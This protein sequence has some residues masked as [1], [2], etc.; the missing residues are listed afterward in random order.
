MKSF[1]TGLGI[2][3]GLGIVFAPNSGEVT[4]RQIR[5]RFTGL[6]DELGGQVDKAK[7]VVQ[8]TVAAYTESSPG[9]PGERKQTG[10]PQKK[11]QEREVQTAASGDPVN[12][13]SREELMNVDGIGPVLADKIISGRPYSSRQELVQ[14][15]IVPQNTFEELE[16][17]LSRQGRRSA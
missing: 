2:G 1:L 8:K 17:E 4:R 6:A 13:I 10:S 16:R 14:R 15:G 5:E 11:M 3:V 9:E 12:T 7:G